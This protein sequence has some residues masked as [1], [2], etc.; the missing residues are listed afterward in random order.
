MGRPVSGVDG[1]G[2]A[3]VANGGP[4][5]AFFPQEAAQ[6][7]VCLVLARVDA[8]RFL[9]VYARFRTASLQGLGAAHAD[10]GAVVVGADGEGRFEGRH[11]PIEPVQPRLHLAQPDMRRHQPGVDGEGTPVAR[12]GLA[13]GALV[14]QGTTQLRGGAVPRPRVFERKRPVQMPGLGAGGS[15]DGVQIHEH[16]EHSGEAAPD[17]QASYVPRL[18]PK[19]ETAQRGDMGQGYGSVRTYVQERLAVTWV[20]SGFSCKSKLA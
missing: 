11:G 4:R 1:E 8:Q 20:K 2:V 16:I 12:G 17:D 15:A 18:D 13:E 3:A 19:G 6:A 10:M 9:E 14:G 5:L 7:D